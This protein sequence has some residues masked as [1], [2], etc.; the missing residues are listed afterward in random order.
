MSVSEWDNMSD[1]NDSMIPGTVTSD[2]SRRKGLDLLAVEGLGVEGGD[3]SMIPG[4]DL[5][6]QQY[7][8]RQLEEILLGGGGEMDSVGMHAQHAQGEEMAEKYYMAYKLFI[9]VVGLCLP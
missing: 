2:R 5:E 1:D 8:R 4:S 7:K 9:V 6:T 3:D